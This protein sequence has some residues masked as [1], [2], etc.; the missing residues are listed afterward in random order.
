MLKTGASDTRRWM[1]FGLIQVRAKNPRTT[2]GIEARI[3][4]TGFRTARV[5]LPAYS[6]RNKAEPI[7]S[8]VATTMAIAEITR[9]P[10]TIVLMSYS[11]RRG[12]HPLVHNV[13]GST[14][15]MKVRAL[16]KRETMMAA[17]ITIEIPAAAANATRTIVSRRR[18]P[19]ATR[20]STTVS[21]AA[22]GVLEAAVVIGALILV[23]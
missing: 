21:R 11:P 15:R 6:D 3:S 8:G 20:R 1:R 22:P 9:V 10:A 19:E 23:G 2:L 13:A 14:L 12:N 7:P 18:R 17:L 4:S 16:P 5:R